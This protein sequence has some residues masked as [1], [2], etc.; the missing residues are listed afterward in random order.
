MKNLF[1]LLCL[2]LAFSTNA[3][4]SFVRKSIL[5]DIQKE[6]L[7]KVRKVKTSVDSLIYYREFMEGSFK[8]TPTPSNFYLLNTINDW[9][10]DLNPP[11]QISNFDEIRKTYATQNDTINAEYGMAYQLQGKFY[12]NQ[13]Q[14]GVSLDYYKKGE[15]ILNLI[16][17]LEKRELLNLVSRMATGYATL[18]MVD[19]GIEY[20]MK[21]QSIAL[22]INEMRSYAATF[23]TL[24]HVLKR[25]DAFLSAL[26]FE[27]CIYQIEKHNVPIPAIIVNSYMVLAEIQQQ[28]E[29]N[30]EK[31][32]EYLLKCKEYVDKIE[33]PAAT[34]IT[35]NFTLGDV[36]SSLN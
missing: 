11:Y 32:L 29:R 24:G 8:E 15:A 31:A 27:Q 25:Y 12:Y 7:E 18:G 5:N 10:L 4:N 3:Q 1:T 20:T 2:L 28:H 33:L 6:L 16:E 9:I 22:E 23:N 17:N 19:Q 21:V 14:Y 30:D 34:L 36:Y 26:N 13:R 35:F